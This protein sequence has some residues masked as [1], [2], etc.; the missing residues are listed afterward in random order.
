MIHLSSLRF[1]TIHHGQHIDLYTGRAHTHRNH[2]HLHIIYYGRAYTHKK[3]IHLHT[4]R[5]APCNNAEDNLE[6]IILHSQSYSH[7][8]PD[9]AHFCTYTVSKHNFLQEHTHFTIAYSKRL[10]KG[11]SASIARD[12]WY[13]KTF[14]KHCW[15]YSTT[16]R[17]GIN[18]LPGT[19]GNAI[20]LPCQKTA[21]KREH[22]SKEGFV[23]TLRERLVTHNL[24]TKCCYGR[25]GG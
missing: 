24:V 9:T 22:K 13:G 15:G 14:S 23:K 11:K 3:H 21:C 20:K 7:S 10:M 1:A 2:I 12:Q 8:E 6:N 5:L 4:I 18:Y 17:K 19:K 16:T 25:N